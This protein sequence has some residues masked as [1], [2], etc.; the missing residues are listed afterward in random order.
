[1]GQNNLRVALE[2]ISALEA[3]PFRETNFVI[4]FA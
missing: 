1:M 2:P 3:A 4:S